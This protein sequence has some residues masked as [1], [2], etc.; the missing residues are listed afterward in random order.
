MSGPPSSTNVNASGTGIAGTVY[1]HYSYPMW[2]ASNFHY[3]GE[4]GNNIQSY[5]NRTEVQTCQLD[6]L[7]E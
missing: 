6:T 7:S 3:C 4:P 5:D 2:N 1:Q